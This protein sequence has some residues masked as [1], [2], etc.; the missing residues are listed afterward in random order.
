MEKFAKPYLLN[1]LTILFC[2]VTIVEMVAEFFN[3]KEIIWLTK[4]FLMPLLL[5]IYAL[6]SERVNYI[7]I[8]AIGCSWLSNMFFI[9]GRISDLI[10]GGIIFLVYRLLILYLVI[11]LVKLPSVLPIILGSLPF[12]FI[13]LYVIWDLYEPLGKEVYLFAAQGIFL[14]L[15]GGLSV[16][17]Y[18]M[19][20]NKANTLLLIST[21]MFAA[22]QFVFMIRLF[23]VSLSILQ[24]AAIFLYVIGQFTLCRFVLIAQCEGYKAEIFE[25][26]IPVTPPDGD[27]R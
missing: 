23:Y 26:S 24:S 16:G 15:L 12:V 1:L 8:I 17:S 19:S 13:Y 14:S 27:F 25:S 5:I 20:S 3:N 2:V 4:P 18:I 22:T 11:R 6:S 9:S 21:M 10:T 7:F